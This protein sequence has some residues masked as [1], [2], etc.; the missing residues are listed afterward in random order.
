MSKKNLE[1]K[2]GGMFLRFLNENAPTIAIGGAIG[3][4]VGALWAA[5]KAS[6]NVSEAKEKFDRKVEEMEA[7]GL[8]ED[9]KAKKMKDLKSERNTRYI[10]AYKWAGLLGIGSIALMITSNALNGAKIAGITAIAMANQDKLKKLAENGRQMIGE[11]P[12]K[13]VEDKTLEDMISENF[14]G[15]DGPKARRLNPRNG[16]IWIDSNSAVIFQGEEADIRD[17]L[18]R[19]QEYFDKYG[20]LEQNKFF[21]MLGFSESPYGARELYWGPSNPFKVSVGQRNY[22]GATFPSIE[23]AHPPIVAKTAGLNGFG[24]K[25]KTA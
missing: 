17:A 12:W 13:E 25:E 21:E 11:A 2:A 5:F 23:Y 24:G 1:G 3:T 7:E 19:A 8:S 6:Q 4:L 9:E 10:L 14:F 16:R 18:E 20:Y 22:L 15:S